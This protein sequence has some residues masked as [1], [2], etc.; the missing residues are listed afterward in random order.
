MVDGSQIDRSVD[1]EAPVWGIWERT[2]RIPHLGTIGSIRHPHGTSAGLD[3]AMSSHDEPSLGSL[4][5]MDRFGDAW[6]GPALPGILRESYARSSGLM[7][8]ARGDLVVLRNADLDVLRTHPAVGHQTW[9]A[10]YGSPTGSSD[11][12][13]LHMF[14][15]AST[16][17]LRAPEHRPAKQTLG[18]V[19][20][21]RAMASLT[22]HADAAVRENVAPALEAEVVDFPRR[23]ADAIAATFWSKVLDAPVASVAPLVRDAQRMMKFFAKRPTAELWATAD[24]ASARFMTAL[25]EIIDRAAISGRAPLVTDFD[26]HFA[27]HVRS[28][29]WANPHQLLGAGLFDGFTALSSMLTLCVVALLESG[30]RPVDLYEHESFGRDGFLEISRLHSPVPMITRQALHDFKYA[31]VTVAEGTNIHLLWIFGNRDP[32]VFDDPHAFRLERDQRSRQFSFGGGSYICAGR[33]L[34]RMVCEVFLGYLA[35]NRVQLDQAGEVEW[36]ADSKHGVAHL[37]VHLEQ[38]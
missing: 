38:G 34:V 36:D 28:E 1:P 31:G 33:N 5:V 4:P 12:P 26:D 25:V 7:R 16:F 3:P 14:F 21:P 30:S 6:H 11:W 23:V 24:A 10:L 13:G 22:A 15:G 2:L 9:E 17:N 20:S 18:H 37:P 29:R 19:M 8:T 35:A 27:A 32:S